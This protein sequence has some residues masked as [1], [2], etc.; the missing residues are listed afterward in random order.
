MRKVL[1]LSPHTD[2]VEL[3]CGATIAKFSELGYEF[4]VVLGS[5]CRESVPEG[6][7]DNA[8]YNEFLTSMSF[9]GIQHV[10][11]LDLPVRHFPALRQSILESFVQINKKFKP[12]LVLTPCSS[13]IHQDHHTF[14]EESV[15]AFKYCRIL[16]YELPWNNQTV[17]HGCH[18]KVEAH[19][20]EKKMEALLKYKSQA[21]RTY[22][23]KDFIKYLSRIRGVQAGSEFAESY[24]SIKWFL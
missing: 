21:G 9:L 23:D 5:S 16:G 12:D 17:I 18:V 24:E 7:E 15:R 4:M 10:E 2:D 3:G 22:F 8:M 19:H 11:F 13:D 14:Y 6:F 20:L 1:L